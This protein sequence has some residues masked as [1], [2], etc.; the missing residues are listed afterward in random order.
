MINVNLTYSYDFSCHL[1]KA[2]IC[3]VRLPNQVVIQKENTDSIKDLDLEHTLNEF[4]L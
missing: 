2:N 3:I 4:V 1:N